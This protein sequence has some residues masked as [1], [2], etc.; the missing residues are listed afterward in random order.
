[1]SVT[2]AAALHGRFEQFAFNRMDS[3]MVLGGIV[4]KD[5]PQQAP[6]HCQTTLNVEDS[7]PAESVSQNTGER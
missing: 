5:R 6:N 1:M 4:D 3:R 7:F 2:A